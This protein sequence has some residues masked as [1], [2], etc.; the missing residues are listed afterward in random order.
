MNY[1]LDT[2]FIEKPGSIELISIGI[3]DETGK[4]LYY[5]ISSEYNPDNARDWVKKN[6]IDKLESEEQVPRKT[7]LQI[8]NEVISYIEFTSE[9]KLLVDKKKGLYFG[10]D[11][12]DLKEKEQELVKYIDIQEGEIVF[13]AYFADYDWVVFCWLFGTMMDLPNGMPRYCRDLKQEMDILQ[14]PKEL[15]PSQRR[16]DVAKA[17][18]WLEDETEK[19]EAKLILNSRF[20]GL[21]KEKWIEKKKQGKKYSSFMTD[22][23]NAIFDAIWNRHLHRACI[24]Y[25][26]QKNSEKEHKEWEDLAR[27]VE[28]AVRSYEIAYN[29]KNKELDKIELSLRLHETK[30][31]DDPEFIAK[32]SLVLRIKEL[33]TS[34]RI[35]TSKVMGFR[36]ELERNAKYDWALRLYREMLYEITETAMV[37][38]QINHYNKLNNANRETKPGKES[39]GE[40]EEYKPQY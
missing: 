15:K 27:E 17:E 28:I 4:N 34:G 37:F 8:K 18:D 7:L 12:A 29:S 38:V 13:W 31:Y 39:E 3:V 2:E 30:I 23:H 32:A 6:V 21:T 16:I 33:G 40:S 24:V 22:E 5:A 1:Y 25:E 19:E 35:I 20:D 36:N 11:I 14:L 26:A 9:V 10:R